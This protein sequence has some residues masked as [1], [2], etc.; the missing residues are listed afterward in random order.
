MHTHS[1]VSDGTDTAPELMRN[2]A[3][4]GLDVVALTDHDT[5]AGWA[6]AA[7]AVSE[8]G[9]ALVRG[10]EVSC[11]ADGISVHILSYLHDPGYA[12]L[13]DAF[14]AS[15]AARDTRAERMVERLAEDFELSWEDVVR[16][17]GPGATIGRPHIA[18]ALVD[19][20]HV[21]DRSAAFAHILSPSGPYYVRYEVPEAG[22]AVDLIVRAGGVPVVAHVRAQARGRIISDDVIAD[23]VGRGMAGIEVDH[24]DHTTADRE[25]LQGLARE[26]GVFITGSSDY[27][28]E[29][30]PNR[31]G[32]NTT[33]PE[34]LERI[35]AA[36]A[37][38]VLRP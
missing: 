26:L 31:L 30:K 17:V 9:V 5:T 34:V 23:L 35:E 8:S 28:G 20:G 15:R 25:H 2:A 3:R 6:E 22:E 18:D 21:A 37:I 10:T 29:G 38:E 13:S 19:R 11:T 1:W 7:A 33:D 12:P 32:E 24:R 4:A 27:H 14:T 16:G 36:G